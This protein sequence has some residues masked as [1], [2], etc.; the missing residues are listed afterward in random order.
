M[1]TPVIR[2]TIRLYGF[3]SNIDSW[4][5]KLQVETLAIFGDMAI[6]SHIM[7]EKRVCTYICICLSPVNTRWSQLPE[8]VTE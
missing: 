3:Q 5:K 6:S 1:D 2:V 8:Q 7:K 4:E